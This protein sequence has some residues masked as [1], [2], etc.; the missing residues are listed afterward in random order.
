[1]ISLVKPYLP[2]SENLMKL[3]ESTLY[4]GYIAEGELTYRFES[5]LS[6]LLGNP[7]C[8]SLNSGTAALHIAL[9]LI[10]VG[11]DDEV[12]ST[13]LTAEP[14]NTTIALTGAKVVFSDVEYLTGLISPDAIEVN[15]T[16]RT[17][18]IMVV[19]YAGMVCDMDRINEISRKY[20]IPVI[21]DAA[22]AFMSKFNNKYIGSNSSYTC[23]S[24]QAIKHL[25]T[26]DGGLLCLKNEAEYLRAKRLRW[27]G[28]DK[29]VPRLESNI[30]EPGYKYHMNNV[31]ATLGLAQ[32]QHLDQNV[33]KYIENGKFFDEHLL[34]I[35]GLNLIP[36]HKNTEPSY[37]LYTIKVDR[38][39]DFIKMMAGH[40][41]A[42]SPLHLRN[43]RHQV[44]Y[45]KNVH[46]P[47]L[48]RFY[49]EFVHIPCGWWVTQEDRAKIVEVINK[50]W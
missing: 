45:T 20:N 23:F 37:W 28:L 5:E 25:T 38:R 16:E 36:Y 40:G 10:G 8:I 13:A 26:I 9:M 49:N 46:L 12:I 47:N 34:N 24:F 6:T 27:F 22:H 17:K 11:K 7:Y 44:F 32:L 35:S 48:D 29:K 31:N 21:E 1:M 3:L 42:A 19:H 50:G 41:I 33:L 43:D 2:S 14:T 4:S 18:A 15:I 30:T 39:D